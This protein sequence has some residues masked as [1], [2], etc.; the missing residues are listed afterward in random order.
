MEFP[1]YT[2]QLLK[3]DENGFAV[4]DGSQPQKYRK[5]GAYNIGVNA[6]RS[7]SG[8]GGFGGV[9]TDE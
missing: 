5:G 4:I 8:F 6:H 3:C 2:Q 7:S 1:F 9:S